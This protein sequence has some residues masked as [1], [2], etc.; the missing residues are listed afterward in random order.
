MTITKQNR[1]AKKTVLAS[2]ISTAL[3]AVAMPSV[4]ESAT[5]SA[6]EFA[7]AG[8]V[9]AEI[10]LRYEG[11]DQD[12]DLDN[13]NATTARLRLGYETASLAGFKA[14]VEYDQIIALQDDYH[15]GSSF[16][17]TNPDTSVVA[18][19]EIGEFNRAQISYSHE[20]AKAVLGR[21][22]IILDNARFVGNV[23]WRQNE[24]TYD[25]ARVDLTAVENLSATYVYMN[26]IND[27]K[28]NDVGVKNHL[29]NLGY[30]TQVGKVVTY[31]YLLEEDEDNQ[32]GTSDT[33][34]LSFKGKAPVGDLEVLYAVEYAT[35]TANAGTSGAKDFDAAYTFLEGGVKVSG[36]S[37]LAGYENLGGDGDY[38]FQT[39][40]AT[41]HAFN[42]WADVFL[43]TPANGLNDIYAKAAGKVAGVKLVAV[44]HDFNSD[45]GG[46]DLGSEINLL[47]AKKFTENLTAGVKYANY[48]AGDDAYGKVDTQK[49]W[50]WG[51][52]KY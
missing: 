22:R 27:I 16:D 51:E 7:K 15:S 49:F 43:G 9:I 39:P 25:A 23:G 12:N 50:L 14:L 45:K 28:A 4:A 41:K 52:V 42:G 31:A 46:D 26:Q 6:T 44:Y 11:V 10:R 21:Q 37:L 3:L 13:A 47:A 18:D 48:S 34:G 5:D 32:E 20:A 30:K 2:A 24:Q 33:F 19:G 29:L 36:I 8:D 35:Q 1:F 17:P 38:S 40:L